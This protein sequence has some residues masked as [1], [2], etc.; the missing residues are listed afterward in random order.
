MQDDKSSLDAYQLE[1]PS[2]LLSMS[3]DQAEPI[4]CMA[5]ELELQARQLEEQHLLHIHDRYRLQT[6]GCGA[7]CS[8]YIC[9]ML[10]KTAQQCKHVCIRAKQA[11]MQWQALFASPQSGL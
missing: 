9:M 6:A 1:Q 5:Q 10:T 3:G 4:P 2:G 8:A 11:V 7:S